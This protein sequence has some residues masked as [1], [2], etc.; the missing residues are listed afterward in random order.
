[1]TLKQRSWWPPTSTSCR[2]PWQDFYFRALIWNKTAQRE[3]TV[4]QVKTHQSEM[5]CPCLQVQKN[6]YLHTYYVCS[7]VS[8]TSSKTMID[9]RIPASV[10]PLW[11]APQPQ[12]LHFVFVS[13]LSD[14]LSKT[15]TD[16][17]HFLSSTDNN[18]PGTGN[19]SHGPVH[20]SFNTF[21]T[22]LRSKLWSEDN[23]HW[24]EEEKKLQQNCQWMMLLQ[25]GD[26]HNFS[27]SLMPP[28]GTKP[29]MQHQRTPVGETYGKR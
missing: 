24:G 18:L 26:S 19:K 25:S 8:H 20:V 6:S 28:A 15:R 10:L 2:K 27:I 29:R 17:L 1:M 5:N 9:P 11:Q 7:T 3:L 22:C 14:H 13:P 21:Q 12:Q 23:V 4:R 16:L